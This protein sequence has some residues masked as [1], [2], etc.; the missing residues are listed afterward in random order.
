MAHFY[1]RNSL[2]YE[3]TI[4]INISF[5]R[6]YDVSAN[7]GDPRW[8]LELATTQLSA[9]GTVIP[10]EFVNNTSDGNKLN[11]FIDTAVANIASQ[12]DWGPLLEDTKTPYVY[13]TLPATLGNAVAIESNIDITLKDD[14]PSS[15]LN[16]DNM[17]VTLATNGSVFDIT[18]ACK[19]EGT[20]F[21]YSL[22]WEPPIRNYEYYGGQ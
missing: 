8:L 17:V 12:I 3:Q 4:K 9:S 19:V 6:G 22:H 21:E 7:D 5:V 15:G 14:F 20:P 2:N 13:A 18:N 1:V 16:L 10:P 11:D